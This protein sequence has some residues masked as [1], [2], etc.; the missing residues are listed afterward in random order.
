VPLSVRL[1][2]IAAGF[3][4]FVVFRRSIF[5]GVATGEAVLILGAFLFPKL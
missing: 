1:V 2:A 5:F 4:G 3:A